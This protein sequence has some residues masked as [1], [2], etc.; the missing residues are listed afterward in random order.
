MG[1]L[2]RQLSSAIAG[3]LAVLVVPSAFA[4]DMPVK[5][6]IQKAPPVA[7]MSWTGFY[8]NGGFGY[9]VWAA[10]THTVFPDGT[11]DECTNQVQGGKGW[12]GVV[13]GGFD[14]QIAPQIVIGAFGDYN[15]SD[16]KG[17][18][19]DGNPFFAGDIK[20][21]SAWAVGGRAGWLNTPSVM[22]YVNAG[23]TAARFSSAPLVTTFLGAPQPFATP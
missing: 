16:L 14:Y 19:Q 20:Q 1:K 18:V 10:D 5:A 2:M 9:G 22:S 17:T 13:G 15:F 23:Y 8:V 6:P 12:L 4:A 3:I 7:A 21:K 11:C